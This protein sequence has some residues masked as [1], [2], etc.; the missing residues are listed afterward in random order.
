MAAKSS[1]ALE[2]TLPSDREIVFT[3][4]FDAPRDL[5]F[6]AYTDPIA[7]TQW[8][9]PRR[10]KTTV[11]KMD[12]RPGGAWRFVQRGADGK[13]FVFHGKYREIVP[14]ERIVSTFEFEGMPGHVTVDTLTLEEHEGRTKLTTR[15]LFQTTE[16]RDA[17]LKSGMESGAAE[18]MERLAELLNAMPGSSGEGAREREITI[19]RVFDAPRELVFKAWTDPKHL[20]RWWGPK[21]FTNPVC[22]ADARV[23][24]KWHIV[25]RAPDGQEHPCG[26]VYREVV[27]PERLAFTNIA[28]DK[29][30]NPVIDGFTTVILEEQGDKTK[31]T[32]HT[33]GTAVVD[34]ARAFLK[35][36]EMGWTMT[37]DRLE[38]ELARS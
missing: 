32:L 17:M 33:R 10:Y 5:V 34:Y 20:A 24:G 14:P 27:E 19:T 4:F 36:M 26:G 31:L 15:S 38:E 12:V 21:G 30:G 29:G 28:T 22:E 23:G 6:R 7:I 13:E 25:M 37:L 3:R 35:G 8:W 1:P 2:L 11:D 16:D 18:S 9:G